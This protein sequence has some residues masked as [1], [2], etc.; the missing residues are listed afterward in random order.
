MPSGLRLFF[1]V[2]LPG[3]VQAGLGRL[4]SDGDPAYRWVAP[5]LLHV[6]VVFLG[7]QQDDRLDELR[8]IGDSAARVSRPGVLK[9]GQAGSFGSRRAP[10]VLWIG[11]D[12]DVEALVDLQRRLSTD[13]QTAGTSL[14]ARPYQPHITLARRRD[15]AAPGAPVPWPPAHIPRPHNSRSTG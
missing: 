12:G 15:T 7:Q 9:L 10:G 1:G 4:G 13:L 6:T 11:L 14:E 5:G 3:D 2:A 8:G